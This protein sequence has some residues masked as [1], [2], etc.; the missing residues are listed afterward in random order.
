MTWSFSRMHIKTFGDISSI[1]TKTCQTFS[2]T[3]SKLQK[4]MLTPTSP[5]PPHMLLGMTVVS[6][7]PSVL[8]LYSSILTGLSALT[9]SISFRVS[10]SLFYQSQNIQIIC[11]DTNKTNTR[12]VIPGRDKLTSLV[13]HMEI[14][15]SKNGSSPAWW[16]GE[17]SCT[18]KM[19]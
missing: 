17:L 18:C 10:L 14:M 16:P 3:P 8:L 12:L 19:Q 5:W 6:L 11:R 13:S 4:R 2:L 15:K 9:L 7:T 1:L